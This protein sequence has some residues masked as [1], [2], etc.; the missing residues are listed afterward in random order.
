V[1]YAF[2]GN[3]MVSDSMNKRLEIFTSEG[4]QMTRWGLGQFFSPCGV[5]VSP[6]NN[7][8]VSDSTEN[9]IAIYKS[10]HQCLGRFGSTGKGDDQFMTPLYVVSG[11]HNEIVV[12]DSDNHCVKVSASAVQG[13]VGICSRS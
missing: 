8:I 3:I 12:S 11:P 5:T 4:K 1:F 6:N 13:Q 9:K 2:L 10:E 7:C